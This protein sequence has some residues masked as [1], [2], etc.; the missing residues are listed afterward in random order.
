MSTAPSL[1]YPQTETSLPQEGTNPLQPLLDAQRQAFLQQG[2]S[3]WRTRVANLDKLAKAIY[4][5]QDQII[6]AVMA[7]FGQRSPHE[8]ALTEVLS[9]L[10]EIRGTKGKIKSWMKPKKVPVSLQALPATGYALYQPKGVVG[11]MGA[12]NY[13]AFLMF[14]PLIGA[15]AAGNHAMLK[16]PDATPRTG[17]VIAELITK[18]FDP[19]LVTV[20]TGG[21][22]EAIAF[23][24]LPF[25]H[26]LYTGNTNVGRQVMMAAARNLTPVTLEMGGKSPVIVAEGYPMDKAVQRIMLGKTVN[27]GQTC[28]APDYVMVPS[29][30]EERFVAA[31]ARAISRRYPALVNNPDLTWIINERHFKRIQG[32]IEDARQKGA[33]VV[34]INPKNE[35]IPE[36]ARLIPPTVL[37]G[38]SDAMAVMQEEIFGP[39]LPVMSYR[40]LD[41]AIAFVQ[42]RPRPLALYCFDED[43]TRAKKTIA[44]T[45]SGGATV[46]DTMLHAAHP[47][48]PFGGIGPSGLG[49]YHGIDGFVEF[50]H[51]KG[52]LV[53]RSW[54]SPAMLVKGPY[55]PKA[56]GWMQRAAK[57]LAGQ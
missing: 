50:S 51:K 41:E 22:Q 33:Q 8:T 9:G 35:V 44:Q 40:T 49:A 5:H 27:A 31:Y 54:F 32:L 28:I 1:V 52:V 24:E 45:I 14:S 21:V 43:S 38:V 53:Q 26:L 7:D 48:L 19:T 4:S 46:N 11:I 15:L 6:K 12:W 47:N 3:D 23:S 55:N 42:A 16:P 34:T 13:P 57:W 39:V 18:T 56:L 36:G 29:G 2:I 37:T 25:D 10:M 17:E 30:Q 20:V